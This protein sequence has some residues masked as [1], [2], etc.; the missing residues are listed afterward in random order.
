LKQLLQILALFPSPHSAHS[1][2]IGKEN[3]DEYNSKS[4]HHLTCFK[5]KTLEGLDG[6]AALNSSQQSEVSARVGIAS[7]KRPAPLPSQHTSSAAI[8]VALPLNPNKK[9]KK[10]AS[11]TFNENDEGAAASQTDPFPF[12]IPDSLSPPFF[13][14]L[15]LPPLPPP[16][17]PASMPSVD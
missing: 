7:A 16:P 3:N 4:W 17:Q 5:L 13:L 14:S 10:K 6:F 1:L 8:S 2:R 15:S 12:S 9:S 11:S